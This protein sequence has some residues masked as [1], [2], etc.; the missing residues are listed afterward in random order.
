M[1]DRL[2]RVSRLEL[3]GTGQ[4]NLTPAPLRDGEG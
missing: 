3:E 1:E 4:G 2:V